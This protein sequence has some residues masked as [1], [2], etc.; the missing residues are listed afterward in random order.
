MDADP[1]DKAVVR[2]RVWTALE[3]AG[4]V[5]RG[6]HGHIPDFTGSA[7]AAHLLAGLDQWRRART[8]KANPDRAQQPV[9]AASLADGKL[10]FMAVPRLAEEHPFLR[11]DPAGLGDEAERY[12]DRIAAAEAGQPVRIAEMPVID[13]VVCGSVAANPDGVRIGKGAG[14]ADLEL[15][16]LTQAGLVT[17]KTTIVTTVHEMQVLDEP[18]PRRRHDFT[19]D[20]IA[21]PDRV[22]TCGTAHRP[23]GIDW[24]ELGADQIRDIPVLRGLAGS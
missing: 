7:R 22:I 17:E 4:V 13:L 21:T 2:D 19:V 20:F 15:A 5:P 12:A 8:V 11:L 16:L 24:D 14:Y 10:L 6:V 1:A 9:R 23:T 3:Q 18:L